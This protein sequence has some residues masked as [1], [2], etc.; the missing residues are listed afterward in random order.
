MHMLVSM[1]MIQVLILKKL[2]F[3]TSIHFLQSIYA[4]ENM[5]QIIQKLTSLTEIA[6]I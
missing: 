3:L 6:K 2:K 5:K 1:T 4:E